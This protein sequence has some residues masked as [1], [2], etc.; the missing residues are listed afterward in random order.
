MATKEIRADNMVVKF[1]PLSYKIGA[2]GKYP[3][4]RMPTACAC[5]SKE[6]KVQKKCIHTTKLS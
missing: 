1:W 4:S 6:V 5:E 2:S 3:I